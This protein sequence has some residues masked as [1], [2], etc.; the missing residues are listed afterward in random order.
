MIHVALD[1]GS[2]AF[3]AYRFDDDGSPIDAM[4]SAYGIKFVGQNG[5]ES[6]MRQQVGHWIT[7][8]DSILLA[9]MIT[10]RNGWL[11]SDY[12]RCPADLNSIL[13]HSKKLDLADVGLI[14]LPGVSQASPADVIR[15]EE[16]QLLGAASGRDSGIYII[17]G[18]HSK[19]ARIDRGVLSY[20]RTIPTGELFDLITNHSLI[21]ALLSGSNRNQDAFNEGVETGFHSTAVISALFAAR[22]SILLG[23]RAAE[24][25]RSWLSGLLIGNEIREGNS[26]LPDKTGRPVLIGTALLCDM[27]RAAFDFLGIASESAP[28]DVTIKGFQQ[29]IHS[30]QSHAL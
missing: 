13:T 4:E 7:P 28:D 1:W 19:W 3:R 18:T 22:S 23:Q 17:P 8:G 21:G 30:S 10:S 2:S 12:M 6:V 11:E 25:A 29:I 16:V 9:G 15:G 5:F 26:M 20:F 14:F 24:D 27:Y